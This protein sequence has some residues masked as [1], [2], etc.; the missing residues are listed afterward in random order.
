MKNISKITLIMLISTLLI[1][2]CSIP[3]PEVIENENVNET[4]DDAV[5][6][7]INTNDALYELEGSIESV[8]NDTL[9]VDGNLIYIN[10][11][12]VGDLSLF[13][14]DLIRIKGVQNEDGS[15]TATEIELL[16]SA[17]SKSNE[18]DVV[19]DNANNS[20]LNDNG[21]TNSNTNLNSNTNDSNSNDDDDDD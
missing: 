18:S 7:N 12:V 4:M 8:D 9:V 21:N 19:N 5:N 13:S 3:A 17:N 14:G 16:E 15:I 10:P 11:S 1:S 2:A 6:E 20:N